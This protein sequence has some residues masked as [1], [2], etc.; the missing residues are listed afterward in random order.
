MISEVLAYAVVGGIISSLIMMSILVITNSFF[1][2]YHIPAYSIFSSREPFP[3]ILERPTCVP[4][5]K[6]FKPFGDT[7][8]EK[9]G[10]IEFQKPCDATGKNCR[11]LVRIPYHIHSGAMWPQL[12][13]FW[14]EL[15]YVE[16]DKRWTA[17]DRVVLS[18]DQSASGSVEFKWPLVREVKVKRRYRYNCACTYVPMT[19][20]YFVTSGL[21]PGS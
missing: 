5:K 14:C 17:Y 6:D 7:T 19:G 8:C 18:A 13:T 10:K 12:F 16:A 20:D 21:I 15:E 11:M 2:S 1:I 9:S 4:E 3:L